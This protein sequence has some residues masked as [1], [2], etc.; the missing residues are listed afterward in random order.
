MKSQMTIGKKLMLSFSALL[1]LMLGLAYSSLS[2]TG[3]L[4][5]E[6]DTAINKT[7]K[8]TELAGQIQTAVSDMR[9]GQRGLILFSMLKDAPKVE[10]ARETF[11]AASARVEKAM[12]EIRPMLVTEVGRQAVDT[13]QVQT[14]AW[15]PLYQ[16]IE[17]ACAAQRFDAAMTSTMDRTVT[18]AGQM[19][20]AADRLIEQQWTLSKA[21]AEKAS[22]VSSRSRWLAF[23]LIGVCLA[24]GGVVLWLVRNI[25]STLRHLAGELGE[26]AEQVASA[27]S[28][29]SASSQSLAQGL[30]RAGGVARRDLRVERGDQ[31]DGAQ[32]HRELARGGR[33]GDAVAAEV[34]PRPTRRS[35]RW[36]WP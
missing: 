7:A 30:V 10:M 5:A 14:G 21:A 26:G 19:Q 3:T 33:P 11:R 36:W 4:S 17:R 2:S 6:L 8:K 24:L 27:A 9:A 29:V 35:S 22:A 13:I 25:S 31:L 28:Q 15:M 18:M 1:A 12:V 32:E 23:I 34:R 16:E 20:K